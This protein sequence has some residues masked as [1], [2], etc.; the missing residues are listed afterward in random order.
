[1]NLTYL[2][3]TLKFLA[4]F[5]L[6]GLGIAFILLLLFPDQLLP[7]QYRQQNNSPL[8]DKN[9]VEIVSY[10]VEIVSYHDAIS[11]T[12]P[13]VVNV[14]ATQLLEQRVNPLL[15]DPL[16]RYFFGDPVQDPPTNDNLGSGVILNESGYLLTNA[17][18][19]NKASEI[20]VTLN[21]GRRAKAEI[22]GVDTETDLAVLHI[23]LENLP[24]APIGNS[25]S[26]QVGDIVLAIGNPY[27]F[28]QTVTQGIVSATRRSRL[29]ILDIEEFIQT[30]AAINPGNSGGALI[31]ARGELIGIN[32]LIY[33]K[34][35]G[36]QGIGFAIPVDLA[37][38]VMRQLIRHG[39]VVRGW[40]GIEAEPVP[41]DI[42]SSA[43]L[44]NSG[45]FVIG[46]YNDSPAANAGIMPGDI[47]LKINGT[48]LLDAQQ[49]FQKISGL[50]PGEI[51]NLE[52]LRGW[53]QHF[54]TA[55]IAQRPKFTR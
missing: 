55:E 18:V 33:S 30:D 42:A 23:D 36:S 41:M 12:A 26:L 43:N 34:T 25:D 53:E 38:D 1:M 13:A 37:I 45:I 32:T 3:K 39:F 5:G 22:V 11:L 24:V 14:Y 15:Q 44:N 51:I 10:P 16:Y 17:H 29:G 8:P 40:L 50:T 6:G 19:I 21:D 35:G 52:I 46:V 4:Q 54:R 48:P 31:N 27:N 49:A 28:G 47:I 20:Q 9:P 7:V 2:K